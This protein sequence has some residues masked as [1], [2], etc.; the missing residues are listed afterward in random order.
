MIVYSIKFR[1]GYA[2]FMVSI[3]LFNKFLSY[4]CIVRVDVSN[5][6]RCSKKMNESRDIDSIGCRARNITI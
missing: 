4:Q 1:K 2:K 3:A 5:M 6:A